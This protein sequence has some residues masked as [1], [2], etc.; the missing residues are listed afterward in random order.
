MRAQ[1]PQIS[2]HWH[3]ESNEPK[4]VYGVDFHACGGAQEGWRMATAGA[5][6]TVKVWRVQP[7]PDA[8]KGL[9]V[10]FLSELRHKG[11]VNCVRF[12]PDGRFLAAGDDEGLVLLWRQSDTSAPA[13][14][15]EQ[16]LQ[17]NVEHWRPA[18]RLR[19]HRNDVSDLAWSPD[20][21]M[22]LSGSVDNVG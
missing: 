22:L 16:E 1:T 4:P 9:A 7:Q 12:S 3:P 14:N 6:S 13:G 21:T 17:E 15:L 20:S 8:D 5:D 10:T 2:W 19:L 11:A 18:Q